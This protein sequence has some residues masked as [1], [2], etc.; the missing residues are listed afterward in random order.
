MAD[1]VY[2]PLLLVI[3]SAIVR[4]KR[5]A[6]EQKSGPA[7]DCDQSG[8]LNL[9]GWLGSFCASLV[10]FRRRL[11]ASGRPIYQFTMSCGAD[12]PV[13]PMHDVGQFIPRN[14]L[15][16]LVPAPPEM[17]AA[18]IVIPFVRLFDPVSLFC[19]FLFV[20]VPFL[21]SGTEK[22]RKPFGCLA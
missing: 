6:G 5:P 13:H 15:C 3:G 14:A 9:C 19:L 11:S 8:C 7:A 21:F 10:G 16:H 1:I 22:G 17:I 4:Q 12:D 2:F 18:G 20:S